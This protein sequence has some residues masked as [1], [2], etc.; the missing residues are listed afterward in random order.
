MCIRDRHGTDDHRVGLGA[1]NQKINLTVRAAA[2]FPNL[3]LGSVTIGVR[4][5][6]YKRQV[7]AHRTVASWNPYLLTAGRTAENFVLS[8]LPR[9]KAR[10][11]KK[12]SHLKQHALKS[13]VFLKTTVNI[14]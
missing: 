12:L 10:A 13:L 1:S 7:D 2:G 5:D 4:P 9:L 14:P 6:V 3:F 11:L 8:G